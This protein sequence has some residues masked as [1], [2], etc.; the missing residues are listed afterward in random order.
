[1]ASSHA[2]KFPACVAVAL[3]VAS[4]VG[5]QQIPTRPYAEYRADAIISRGSAAQLGAGV[6][7]PL[8]LYVRLDVDA[9]AGATWRYGETFGSGRV[10]AIARFLLDPFRESSLGFSFGGGASVPMGSAEPSQP[11]YLTAVVD[12][13]WS[14]RSG[15]TPALQVGLGGGT[16]IG[17]VL[18]RSP[19]QWR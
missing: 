14:R 7:V 11:P 1:M 3:L 6:V 13:E 9:A 18:R 16:R 5:A 19:L 12:I 4:V 8:G 17:V 10:D 2:L 15:T